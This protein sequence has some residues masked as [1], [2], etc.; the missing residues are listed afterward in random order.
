[1]PYSSRVFLS[2]ALFLLVA[3]GALAQTPT[4][5]PTPTSVASATTWTTENGRFVTGVNLAEQPDGSVWFLIPSNDRIVQLQPDGVTFKQWQIR[6]D[7]NLGANPVDFTIDG[8]YVWFIE[9]GQSEIDAGFSA[10]GR[11]NTETNELHEW[12][13]PGSRPAGFYRAPDGKFWL[14]QSNGRLQSVD[15]DSLAVVDYRSGKTFAYSDMVVAPDGAL[16]MVDFGDNRIVRYVPGAPSETSWTIVAPTLGRLNPTQLQFDDA[17]ELW[18]CEFSG[19]RMD[20]FEPATGVISAYG[21]FLDPIHFDIFNGR[22]YVAE[23]PTANGRVVVLDPTIAAASV[24]LL[25]P[26]TLSVLGT[27]NRRLARIRDTLAIQTTFTSTRKTEADA[28]VKT[29]VVGSGLLRTEFP[30][31][32]AYGIQVNGSG[33]WTGSEGKLVHLVLKPV[34]TATDLTVPVAAQFGV[35]PGPRIAIETTLVNRGT[36]PISGDMLYLFSDASFAP[37]TAFSVDPGQTVI[38]PDTF[39][40]ASSGAAASFGP[41]RVRVTSGNAADLSVSIRSARLRDDGSSFGFALRA[42]SPSDSLGQGSSTTLFLGG[43]ASEVSVFG[44]YAAAAGDATATLVAPDGTVRGTRRFVLTTNIVSEFNPAANAFGVAP[45]TGDV[46][47][48]SVASGSVQAYVNVFDRGSTD[49][50]TVPP[51][52]AAT[53]GVFPNLSNFAGSAGRL[54][55]L[56]ASNPDPTRPVNVT[57]SFIQE[58]GSVAPRLATITLPPG[59]SRVIE[60]ALT[61]FFGVLAGGA[62][63][64]TADG[65]VAVAARVASRRDEGDYGA[66][67]AALL[68]SDAIVPAGAAESLGAPTTDAR[69]TDLLLFNSGAA[70]SVTVIG[71][72]GSGKEVGR[73]SVPIGS[74]GSVRLPAVL[75]TLGGSGLSEARLRVETSAGARIYAITE[76][77]DR[78]TGDVEIARLR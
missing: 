67:M 6:D 21:G 34:G 27:P 15:P 69:T 51:V 19:N 14:P 61:N 11:L 63:T 43:R 13:I 7:K 70:T 33:V 60:N 18:I 47:R 78:G 26:E 77:I 37:R 56:F 52:P 66:F 59:G 24:A 58:D 44:L 75:T 45:E 3:G 55:D 8:K 30:S 48:L 72:D 5:T 28:D 20:R 49:I 2:G 71:L 12:V 40:D 4:P 31:V 76:Q 64:F 36:S 23:A 29:T 25:T 22:V 74:Q 17:G 57:F 1:M 62:V 9:N 35:S 10:L 41:V 38:L 53:E 16:W 50:A 54:S 39:H 32:N 73:R 68:P 42:A 46:I 65:P